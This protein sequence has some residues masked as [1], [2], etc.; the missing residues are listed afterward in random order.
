MRILEAYGCDFCSY[1]G[2]DKDEVADHQY[3]CKWNPMCRTCDTCGHLKHV[4]S[5]SIMIVVEEAE[6]I[7]PDF[8]QYIDSVRYFDVLY[9]RQMEIDVKYDPNKCWKDKRDCKL[10]IPYE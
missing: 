4:H 3:N 5:D 8:S 10:W 7:I 2:F 1:T 6:R 9:C